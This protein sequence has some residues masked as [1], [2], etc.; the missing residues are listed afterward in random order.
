MTLL[1]KLIVI[2]GVVIKIFT[3]QKKNLNFVIFMNRKCFKA[4]SSVKTK[5]F[6]TLFSVFW[7]IYTGPGYFI[8]TAQQFNSQSMG[9]PDKRKPA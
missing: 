1:K 3:S 6:E 2:I 7:N 9:R 5:I 4:I 8:L